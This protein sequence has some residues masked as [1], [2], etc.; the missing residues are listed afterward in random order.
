MSSTLCRTETRLFQTDRHKNRICVRKDLP[1]LEVGPDICPARKP[2]GNRRNIVAHQYSFLV[3]GRFFYN[4][5]CAHIAGDYEPVPELRQADT[6][7]PPSTRD[8]ASFEKQQPAL[9]M[10]QEITV[11]QGDS[12]ETLVVTDGVGDILQ[13]T[14]S[15]KAKA[16]AMTRLRA[17]VTPRPT[18]SQKTEILGSC[19]GRIRSSYHDAVDQDVKDAAQWNAQRLVAAQMIGTL[20]VYE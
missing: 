9:D 20:K 7:A 14:V 1:G 5:V 2:G 16:K 11:T 10:L 8:D 19:P 4:R 15:S 12:A 13:S 17:A 6:F 3:F 18:K